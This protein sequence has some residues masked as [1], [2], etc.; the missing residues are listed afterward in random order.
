M[1]ASESAEPAPTPADDSHRLAD[2]RRSGGFVQRVTAGHALA[3]AAFLFLPLSVL[4][5]QGLALLL[6]LAALPLL[7]RSLRRGQF[8]ALARRPLTWVLAG[9]L[10]WG[11]VTAL[12]AIDAGAVFALWPSLVALFLAAVVTLAATLGLDEAERWVLRAALL[13]G[14]ITGVALLGGEFA[15]GQFFADILRGSEPAAKLAMLNPALSVLL[16]MLWPVVLVAWRW[17]PFAWAVPVAALLILAGVSATA[18]IA[19]LGGVAVYLIVLWGGRLAVQSLTAIAVVLVL[20]APLVPVVAT[21]ERAEPLLEGA[22]PSALHRVYIWEFTAARIAEKPL[23]GWG[24]DSSRSIPGGDVFVMGDSPL[25]SLH[26]H[27]A[28]LQIWLEL[29]LPG[30]LA[31]AALMFLAGRVVAEYPG[32]W[33]AAAMATFATALVFAGLSY[34][35][36]QNWWIATLAMTAVF[37]RAALGDAPDGAPETPGA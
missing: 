17:R 22:R 9:V 8:R 13:W 12:W 4:S 27:N 32:R 35:I 33:R 5:S 26:P 10:G 24:L 29:G 2:A 15:T 31:L 20:A 21:P 25:M 16:L 30:A 37:T 23:L 18:W 3:F 28:P 7:F 34:G 14:F 11:A 19:L 6:S 36:W 1:P